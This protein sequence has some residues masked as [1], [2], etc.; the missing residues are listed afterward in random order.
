M[1]CETSGFGRKER[2]AKPHI[3]DARVLNCSEYQRNRKLK[4]RER[5]RER[6]EGREGVGGKGD[7]GR[8][9]AKGLKRRIWT[10]P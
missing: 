9:R 2:W 10:R 3:L 8:K 4:E 6:K 1:P 7:A 5:E